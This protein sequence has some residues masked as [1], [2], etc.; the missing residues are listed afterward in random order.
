MTWVAAAKRGMEIGHGFLWFSVHADG[1]LSFEKEERRK[2]GEEKS[3]LFLLS[4]PFFLLS[5]IKL[6]NLRS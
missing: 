4:F 1:R 6:F 3:R 2:K 5:K